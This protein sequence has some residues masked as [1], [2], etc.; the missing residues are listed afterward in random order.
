MQTTETHHWVRTLEERREMLAKQIAQKQAIV[1]RLRE[2]E[3]DYSLTIGPA[4]F[5]ELNP[6]PR[7]PFAGVEIPER[8]SVRVFTR[9]GW[10]IQFVAKVQPDGQLVVLEHH[11]TQVEGLEMLSEAPEPFKGWA[12]EGL[13]MLLARA[14]GDDEPAP[15]P[16]RPRRP[17]S[18]PLS[19]EFLQEVVRLYDGDE[20]L[21]LKQVAERMT[22]SPHPA[23]AKRW[24][25]R[26]EERGL[27]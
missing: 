26:A 8:F 21:S 16:P 1:E 20:G 27:R 12:S 5:S 14:A 7:I 22:G 24:L 2:E 6:L 17:G 4:P 18:M 23:T 9:A 25:Q 15:V 3:R 19:D 11:H 10:F 13:T